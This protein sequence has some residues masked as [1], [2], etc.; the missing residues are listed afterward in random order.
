MEVAYKQIIFRDLDDVI[1]IKNLQMQRMYI[2]EDV[3]ADIWRFAIENQTFEPNDIIDYIYTLYECE[4][5]DIAADVKT[6]IDDL[7]QNG[8]LDN[9]YK[10]QSQ[11]ETS[12][13]TK[14]IQ[15]IEGDVIEL[16]KAKG[17]AYSATIEITYSCNEKCV[18]CYANY[19]TFENKKEK[20]DLDKYISILDQLYDMKCMHISYTGGDPFVFKDFYKVIE[21]TRLKGF[22]FDIY[23]NAQYLSAHDNIIANIAELYPQTIFI[24]LYGSN[25]KTHDG[26]TQTQG[27]FDRTIYAITKIREVKIPIVLNIMVLN[28]N[29]DDIPKTIELANMLSVD[30]RIGIS[31]IYKN[32]GNNQPMSYFANNEKSVANILCK[33]KERFVSMDK[34]LTS[35]KKHFFCNTGISMLSI[36]PSGI[37]YP[38]ISFKHKLG[39]VLKDKIS[40]VWKST[41]R[42]RLIKML[43]LKRFTKCS[44]CEYIEFCPHC[45]GISYAEHGD[46]YACNT[47]DS[48]IAKCAYKIEQ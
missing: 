29:I 47:C 23:T 8:L 28:L 16:Y 25:A 38:C 11:F 44:S 45:I 4:I 34:P 21:Y 9:G 27:S 12:N 14:N 7:L 10:L 40:D 20:L 3:A 43:S 13:T 5:D 32:D 26:I 31:L 36:S 37:I 17:L 42:Q 30:Y 46:I 15:D 1:V 18:H 6:F 22:S 2:L 33:E 35:K 41:E 48:F 19:P 24:S 39:N